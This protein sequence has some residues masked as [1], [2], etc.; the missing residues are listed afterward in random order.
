MPSTRPPSPPA[1]P[2]RAGWYKRLFAWV[3]SKEDERAAPEL[4]AR[5]RALL[6]DVAGDVIEVGPGAGAN[7]RYYPRDIHWVGVEPNP[8]MDQ[9]IQR[10]AARW[11]IAAT[12][13]RGTAEDLPAGDASAD[14]VVSTLVLC[15]VGDVAAALGEVRRVL[16]PGGRFLF[17]EHVAA[18]VGTRQRRTQ[19]LVRPLW[20]K[21]ADGCRPDQETARMIEAADFARV[22]IERFTARL[23]IVGSMIIG[24]AWV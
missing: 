19:H 17:L 10:E 9:Y 18:P 23:P 7:L 13:R 8:Y 11:G 24:T 2:P 1:A 14:V 20:G 15:S 16:R 12:V 21:L 6:A 4:A 5:K 22:E 3:L